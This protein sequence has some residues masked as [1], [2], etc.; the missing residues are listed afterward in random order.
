MIKLGQNKGTFQNCTRICATPFS[1][2][3]HH[4]RQIQNTHKHPNIDLWTSSPFNVALIKKS[5]QGHDMLVL[6]TIPP[7]I[8]IPDEKKAW[9]ELFFSGADKC[10]MAITGA[11]WQQ[12]AHITTNHDLVAAQ[13][14][15]YKK[16]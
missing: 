5:T 12:S 4:P 8:S 10:I 9:A 1:S 15:P 13:K 3:I 7:N 6:S 14:Q 16:A 11:I 2:Q